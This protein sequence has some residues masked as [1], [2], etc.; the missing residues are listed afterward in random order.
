MALEDINTT[1]L[2]NDERTHLVIH[3]AL[4]MEDVLPLLKV[5]LGS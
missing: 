3:G 2:I 4:N 5:I 1:S